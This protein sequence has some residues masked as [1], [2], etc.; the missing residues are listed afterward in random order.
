MD[1]S[2]GER[3]CS[4]P[5]QSNNW[6]RVGGG[7]ESCQRQACLR[8]IESMVTILYFPN[9]KLHHLHGQLI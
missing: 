7:E 5:L 4:I 9:Q 6:R 3:F 1:G 2:M 8:N